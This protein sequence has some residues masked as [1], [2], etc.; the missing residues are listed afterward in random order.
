[1]KIASRPRSDVYLAG[2]QQAVIANGL[3]TTL[4][5]WPG[6]KTCGLPLRVMVRVS[7]S[8]CVKLMLIVLCC[9]DDDDD[10]V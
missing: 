10:D 9:D 2:V 6:G 8:V 3:C 7:I 4:L 1:M 5:S